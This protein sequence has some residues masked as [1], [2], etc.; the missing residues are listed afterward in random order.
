MWKLAV[1]LQM[2]VQRRVSSRQWQGKAMAGAEWQAVV[3]KARK[4][5]VE[6]GSSLLSTDTGLDWVEAYEELSPAFCALGK[7]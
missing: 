7:N 2:G 6:G 5:E 4:E 1:G 3:L